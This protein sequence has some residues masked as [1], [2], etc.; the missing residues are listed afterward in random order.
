MREIRPSGVTR[1]KDSSLA[2]SSF[3]TLLM[4]FELLRRRRLGAVEV[5]LGE[6]ALQGVVHGA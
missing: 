2:L 6:V 4:E 3:P 1:G 5:Q